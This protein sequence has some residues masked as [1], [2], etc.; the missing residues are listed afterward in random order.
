[1]I[2]DM[3][4]GQY[5][6]TDSIIHK[7]DPRLKIACT[8][9]FLVSLF[10]QRNVLGYGL[11]TLLLATVIIVGGLPLKLILRGLRPILI[12]LLITVIF[13]LFL[14]GGGELIISFGFLNIYE[15]GLRTAVFM[16]VRLVYLIIGSSVMTFTTTP[17]ALTDGLEAL[18]KPLERFRVPVHEVAMMMSIALRFIP[19]LLEE[20]D[21]IRKAQIARGADLDTGNILQKVKATIPIIVPLFISAFRR[22]DDLALA[23][24]S[25]CYH[26]SEGRTKMKPLVY[27]S[28]DYVAY[29][30]M[31]VYFA[32][33]MF[34]GRMVEFSLWIF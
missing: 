16:G 22:A 21:K 20:A 13:N 2:R 32:L 34:V 29:G 8:F 30:I 33:M 5:Y 28:R 31:I 11:A 6:P 27:S 23:M 12:L 15:N 24:E 25:R 7:L 1:M 14:T 26:G 4:I 3:T 18:L 9:I 10:I 17:N 19:I